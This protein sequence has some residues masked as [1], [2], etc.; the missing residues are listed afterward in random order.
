MPDLS[1]IIVNWNSA[2]YLRA[3]LRSVNSF[4]RGI[5]FEVIVVDN[6]SNDGCG[7]MLQAEF[8]S[9]TFIASNENL[10]FAR[11]NNLGFRHATSDILLFLNP[12]TEI[13]GDVF[14][15]MTKWLKEHPEFGA[16]GARLLN[17]DGTLQES[18]VQAFPTIL[19]QVLDAEFL[20]RRFPAS[21]LWGMKALYRPR[22]STE[23][24]DAISGACFLTSR[25]A[26]E[27]AGFFTADY[28]MYSDDL[29]LSHKIWCTGHKVAFLGDC[30]VVH[31]GG[32]SSDRQSGQFA[33]VLQKESMERYFRKTRGRLYGWLYRCAIGLAALARVTIA[34]ALLALASLTRRQSAGNAFK[35]WLAVLA[36][37]F[38]FQTSAHFAGER[39]HA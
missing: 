22:G 3:C 33:A 39:T 12:D 5:A 25:K 20:R 30:E 10:G 19:N 23:T 27:D 37:S 14:T 11:A 17:T 26:F 28:F 4:T 15:R 32:K 36:W 9:T 29:D 24:V 7:E 18:C 38:G 1:I 6:A 21:S 31:H 13:A 8:P 35:K 16:A 34:L 2:D